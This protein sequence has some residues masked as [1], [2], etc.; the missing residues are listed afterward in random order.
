[1]K[2]SH[3]VA[4]ATSA[5]ASSNEFSPTQLIEGMLLKKGLIRV[6]S[7][8][9]SKSGQTLIVKWG[10]SGK[11][12]V[13]RG[14]VQEVTISLVGKATLSPVFTCTAEGYGATE[15]DDVRDAIV[16]CLSGL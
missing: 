4:N 13:T 5:G 9:D 6:D 2:E 3:A 14:F 7:V 11:R 10:I 16:N 12:N 8:Q 1:M 15:I